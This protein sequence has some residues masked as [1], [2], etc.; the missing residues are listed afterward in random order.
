MQ[1]RTL[2]A[3]KLLVYWLPL[4]ISYMLYEY[5]RNKASSI[6]IGGAVDFTWLKNIDSLYILH[7]GCYHSVFQTSNYI[8]DLLSGIVYYIHP[9]DI[10]LL[11]LFFTL[12]NRQQDLL[13][14]SLSFVL[15]AYPGLLLYM[16][17]PSAP[18][19]I[20]CFDSFE[21][22]NLVIEKFL[23][24]HGFP[25]YRDPFP[26]GSFPSLHVGFAVLFSLFLY[27][28]KNTY[29]KIFAIIFPLLIVFDTIYTAN[30]YIFDCITGFLI[31]V[32]G[33]TIANMYIKNKKR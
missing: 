9:F 28:S 24:N 22:K 33:Y 29:A 4:V 27:E 2:R 10:G 19:W 1:P 31:A 16:L 14:L 25:V 32:T 20:T 30:H 17:K 12:K 3:V 8:L 15:T 7:N 5:L 21:R 13:R 18:P 23:L 11:A 6:S 26:I